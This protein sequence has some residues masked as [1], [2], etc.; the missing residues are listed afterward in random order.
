MASIGVGQITLGGFVKL[1]SRAYHPASRQSGRPSWIKTS[2]TVPGTS[3][4]K[5]A[6]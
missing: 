4:R 5:N 2:T 6:N 1:C 3:M